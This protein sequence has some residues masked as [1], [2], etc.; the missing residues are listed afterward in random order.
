[1]RHLVAQ[2]GFSVCLLVSSCLGEAKSDDGPVAIVNGV[3]IR[4]LDVKLASADLANVVERLPNEEQRFAIIQYLIDSQLLAEAAERSNIH[5][6]SI[7]EAHMR[8]ARRRVLRDLFFQTGVVDQISDADARRLYDEEARK[9]VPEDEIRARHILVSTE[10]AAV[11]LRAK[12]VDGA[13]FATLAREASADQG[14]NWNGGDLGYF[15][16]GQMAEEFER[17]AFA[18]KKGELSFPV[19]SQFGWHLIYIEDRRSRAAPSF[20]AMKGALK[21][22]LVYQKSQEVVKSLREKAKIDLLKR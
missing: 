12:I 4:E 18:L 7:F 5:H 20:D 19:K 3:T 13:S 1:M 8:Y 10:A 14:S 22:F 2:F 15:T 17:A 11:E 6:A 21:D 16:K 9:L